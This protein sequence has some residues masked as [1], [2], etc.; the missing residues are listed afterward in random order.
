MSLRHLNKFCKREL[1]AAN[2]VFM[3]PVKVTVALVMIS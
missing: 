1:F 2:G 3:Y